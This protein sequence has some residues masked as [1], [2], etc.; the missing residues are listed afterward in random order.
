MKPSGIRANNLA[1]TI[2]PPLYGSIARYCVFYTSEDSHQRSFYLM[3]IL[4]QWMFP[5]TTHIQTI[6]VRVIHTHT[7]CLSLTLIVEMALGA[8]AGLYPGLAKTRKHSAFSVIIQIFLPLIP[9]TTLFVIASRKNSICCG[10]FSVEIVN[11]FNLYF[12][13]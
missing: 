13:Q 5:L 8:N 6:P 2:N 12:L 3:K 7:F 11:Y 4:H 10:Y 1:R 9:I